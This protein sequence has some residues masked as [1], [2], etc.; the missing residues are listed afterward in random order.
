M[1]KSGNSRDYYRTIK[2]AALASGAIGLVLLTS[3]G[4]SSS[5]ELPQQKGSEILPFPRSI[6]QQVRD[7]AISQ[8]DDTIAAAAGVRG[9]VSFS[10][11][12]EI[13]YNTVESTGVR[14]A[15]GSMESFVGS[16]NDSQGVVIGIIG[17]G[18][19]YIGVEKGRDVEPGYI[20]SFEEM[21]EL[22]NNKEATI[23]TQCIRPET[24][25]TEDDTSYT[26]LGATMRM[27]PGERPEINYTDSSENHIG[28]SDPTDEELRQFSKYMSDCAD[29]ARSATGTVS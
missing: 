5:E 8:I 21:R 13:K 12:G 9:E 6:E 24:I 22:L 1:E 23:I 25:N 3:S 14:S 29:W 17:V 20:P 26:I 10:D 28:V 7:N 15:L 19:Y 2:R 27:K 18:G 11:D 16:P 4:C